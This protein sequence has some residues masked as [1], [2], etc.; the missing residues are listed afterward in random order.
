MAETKLPKENSRLPKSMLLFMCH[1]LRLPLTAGSSS[2]EQSPDGGLGSGFMRL[3]LGSRR[4][5][6]GPIAG[7]E[8]CCQRW[9]TAP[10]SW[11]P[12]SPAEP[13]PWPAEPAAA[14]HADCGSAGAS[15]RR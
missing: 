15:A 7:S 14:E 6:H 1:D 13:W 5:E 8:R 2:T 3:L 4:V 11:R 12:Q 10:S 9:E